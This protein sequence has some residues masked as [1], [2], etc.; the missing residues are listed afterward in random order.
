MQ[1]RYNQFITSYYA[2]ID[3]DAEMK[4]FNENPEIIE[5]IDR[6]SDE[7]KWIAINKNPLLIRYI[8][9]PTNEMKEVAIEKN[10]LSILFIENPSKKMEEIATDCNP[11]FIKCIKDPSFELMW[12]VFNKDPKN[13]RFIKNP[14]NKMIE[15]VLIHNFRLAKWIDK[16]ISDEFALHLIKI[17]PKFLIYYYPSKEVTITLLKENPEL[18]KYLDDPNE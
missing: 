14:P 13:I 5:F 11:M 10:P 8:K 6:Q 9:N 2:N 16:E 12:R 18:S 1:A 15:Q 3:K 7:M 17:N 4:L